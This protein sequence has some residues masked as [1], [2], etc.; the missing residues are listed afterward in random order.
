MAS[1]LAFVLSRAP[2]SIDTYIEKR[3]YS[4]TVGTYPEGGRTIMEC[5]RKEGT[6]GEEG[7]SA[8]SRARQYKRQD[9]RKNRSYTATRPESATASEGSAISPTFPRIYGKQQANRPRF[10]NERRC[11]RASRRFRL[12]YPLHLRST[13][14]PS[15]SAGI[16]RGISD[17]P[18]EQETGRK[19]K[20]K[21][22]VGGAIGG[23]LARSTRLGTVDSHA[24]APRDRPSAALRGRAGEAPP[25]YRRCVGR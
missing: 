13:Q 22:A 12:S 23:S 5:E 14:Q 9:E 1:T 7:A 20:N 10:W 16:P 25:G 8:G 18:E 2:Y 21:R 6:D 17:D 19:K 24:Q 3:V 11:V 15:V 4:T